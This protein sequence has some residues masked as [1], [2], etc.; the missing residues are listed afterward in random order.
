MKEYRIK[1]TI[2]ARKESVETLRDG[3]L[4]VS[5]RVPPKDGRAND[6]VCELLAQY[7]DVHRDKVS[8]R[9]GHTR[10]TKTI[11]VA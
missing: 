5:V 2:G 6:R 3:R 10:S 8:I 9:S 4:L 1:V 7:F 11:R